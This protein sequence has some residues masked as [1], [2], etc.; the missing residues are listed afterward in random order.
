MKIAHSPTRPMMASNIA[1]VMLRGHWFAHPR[2]WS[3]FILNW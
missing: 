2:Y 3:A 1:T